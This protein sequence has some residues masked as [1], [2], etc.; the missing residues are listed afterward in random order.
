LKT[1]EAA[2]AKTTSTVCRQR[3]LDSLL[4][5]P[6]IAFALR[7]LLCRQTRQLRLVKHF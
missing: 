1:A 2:T 7:N 5:L 6:I 3:I 4:S